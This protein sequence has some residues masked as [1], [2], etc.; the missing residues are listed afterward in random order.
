MVLAPC[1]ILVFVHKRG[2]G[3][4]ALITLLF[5]QALYNPSIR[6]KRGV[7]AGALIT[8]LFVQKRGVGAGLLFRERSQSGETCM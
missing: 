4:G 2:V 8:L 5:V 7:G 3:D 1:I 6:K